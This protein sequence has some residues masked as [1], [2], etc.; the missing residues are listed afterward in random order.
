MLDK[1]ISIY[2]DTG[3][4]QSAVSLSPTVYLDCTPWILGPACGRSV[5]NISILTW[6][7]F[8]DVWC[9]IICQ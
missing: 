7:I 6:K 5:E 8:G 1:K 4:M 2:L 3:S 9:Q